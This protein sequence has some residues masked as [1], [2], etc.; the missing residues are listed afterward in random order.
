MKSSE[1]VDLE[2]MGYCHGTSVGTGHYGQCPQDLS[3]T[4]TICDLVSVSYQFMI[5]LNNEGLRY[6]SV[7]LEEDPYFLG[8][9][10][11]VVHV[12]KNSRT[13]ELKLRQEKRSARQGEAKVAVCA[14]KERA[15]KADE[16]SKK[17]KE[18]F[19]KVLVELS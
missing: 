5:L 1:G 12:V 6:S 3:I 17:S 10:T 18:L 19:K 2:K 13:T 14:T 9:H 8:E 4:N 7:P 15:A 11:S 16:K